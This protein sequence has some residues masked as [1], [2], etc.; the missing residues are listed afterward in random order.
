MPETTRPDS[1]RPADTRPPGRPV[2]VPPPSGPGTP[3]IPRQPG[4][5]ARLAHHAVTALVLIT[6]LAAVV[7]AFMF[8]LLVMSSRHRIDPGLA[9]VF[10]LVFAGSLFAA[11]GVLTT[12]PRRSRHTTVRSV[13]QV[14]RGHHGSTS[15]PAT[16]P[17]KESAGAVASAS[18]SSPTASWRSA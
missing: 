4:R 13:R 7:A 6:V 9:E 12:P 15:G 10:V 18:A 11:V 3:T 5:V 2:G 8:A 17:V 16:A 14:L 1:T